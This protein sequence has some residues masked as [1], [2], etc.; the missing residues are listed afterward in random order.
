MNFCVFFC[1][2]GG[3]FVKICF[4]ESHIFRAFYKIRSHQILYTSRNIRW[5]QL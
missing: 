4:R 1:E 5:Q 2:S 3:E